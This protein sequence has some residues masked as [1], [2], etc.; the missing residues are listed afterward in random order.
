MIDLAGQLKDMTPLQRAVVALR[1][2]QARLDEVRRKQ[3]E[4]LAIV[5]MACRFPGGANDP[6]AFWRLL[7]NRVDAIGEVPAD[8]WD[9]DALYDPDAAAPGKMNTRW[10]GFL[11]RIDEFDNRF[12]GI[13]DREAMRMDPQHRMLLELAWESLE[14]AGLPAAGL[15]GSRTGVFIGIAVSDYGLMLANDLTHADAATATGA[16][17]CLAANRLSFAFG[18][19]G[20]SL[21]VDTA[22][23]SSLVALHLACQSIRNGECDVALAGG[24]NLLLSP[25]ASVNLSKAGFC[26]ADGRVRAFDAAASGYVRSEGIGLIVIK[27]LAAVLSDKDRLYAVIRGSA[28]NQ[29]GTSN[30]LT[31]PSRAAQERV[32]REAYARA[33]VSPGQ[34][35]FVETQGTGT[36][37]GDTI[38]ALALGSVLRAD[39]AA[40]SPC[41][42]GAVKTN[43]GHLEAAAGIAG[44]MKTALA[45]QHR[46]LPPN[47]HFRNPNPNIPFHTLPLRVV[48]ELQP[49]PVGP[50]PRLAGV[51]AFGFGGS[52]AHVVLEEAPDAEV[53]EQR[54]DFGLPTSD[55]GPRTSDLLLLPL[56]ARTEEALGDLAARYVE[57]LND[58][59]PLWPDVC[60]TA[61]SRRDHHDC[62]LAVVA[63]SN[64]EAAELLDAYRGGQLPPNIFAGRKPFGRGLKV[65][66][67]FDDQAKGW[68]STVNRL[69]EIIGFSA[70]LE[71]IDTVCQGVAGWSLGSLRGDDPR[72][73]DAAWAKSAVLAWQLALAAWWRRVGIVPHLVFGK[74]V[75]ELAA[76]ATAGIFTAGEV[77]P[78]VA[79]DGLKN[80]AS[81]W[82]KLRPRPASLSFLSTVDGA[83]HAGPD[84]EAEQWRHCLR[85]WGGLQSAVAVLNDRQVDVCL[86]IGPPSLCESLH[87]TCRF[88]PSL[89]ARGGILPT[90]GI[91]YS[92]GADFCWQYLGP[93][94]GRCVRL[95]SYPW[96]RRRFWLQDENGRRMQLPAARA[97][98]KATVAVPAANETAT[99]ESLIKEIAAAPVVRPRPELTSPYI[100]PE[101]PLEQD[102]AAAWSSLLGIDC[103]G[104]H[105][106]FFELG[107]DSLQAMILLN[108]LRDQW[109]ES[110]PAHALF[111]VQTVRDLAAYARRHCPDAVHRHYPQEPV[112]NGKDLPAETRAPN[113]QPAPTGDGRTERGLSTIPRLGRDG[114]ADRL[115]NRLNELSDDEVESLLGEA[116][117]EEGGA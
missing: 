22:C 51:S 109:G 42:L 33:R 15:R 84:V 59:P 56:S 45:L 99:T 39:R 25:V 106:N 6:A 82:T 13:S 114:E 77:L 104:V 66:C 94:N 52:N 34:V 80:G 90:L 81:P 61:G 67:S 103:I 60:H 108:Q 32:L 7:C 62:R 1:E 79:P 91:L 16:S 36:V 78:L 37:L 86:E 50:H 68:Q 24:A 23:S 19:E 89:T 8:R 58:D 46:Q 71:E 29:N 92:A 64:K 47:L 95:P 105:D 3:T 112:A 107:G 57:Y 101:T 20:P 75:G 41:M 18:W 54:S 117:G 49:W 69:A 55:R 11:D 63:S 12:F 113:A 72:W 70:A 31:A 44:L 93:N 97:P 53:G 4:P 110:V 100:P 73:E 74:G 10:G 83:L 9:A 116:L 2:T 21:A 17:L 40:D 35:Q 102:I 48:G 87:P 88:L 38:E 26:A 115:L 111:E 27:P 85:S 14:D 98:A 76:A 65:A 96:Q 28:V 30:G 43:I 5:G